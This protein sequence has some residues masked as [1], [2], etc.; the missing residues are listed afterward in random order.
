MK[1]VRRPIDPNS[2]RLIDQL[3]TCIRIGILLTLRKKFIYFGY[4]D[5]SD[6][7]S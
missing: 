7:V 2:T 1:D 6:L 3:R 4:Y 5:L